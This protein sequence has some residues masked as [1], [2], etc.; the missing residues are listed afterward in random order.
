MK[1]SII[2]W[3]FFTWLIWWPIIINSQPGNTFVLFGIDWKADNLDNKMFW[4][5][6]ILGLVGAGTEVYEEKRKEKFNIHEA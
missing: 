2:P 4:L 5:G 1:H 6:I 3:I